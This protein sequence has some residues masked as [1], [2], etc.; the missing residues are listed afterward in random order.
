MG[1]E[2]CEFETEKNDLLLLFVESP[3]VRTYEREERKNKK[4][5]KKSKKKGQAI[6]LTIFL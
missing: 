2:K 6:P 3:E 1:N 5:K 4:T